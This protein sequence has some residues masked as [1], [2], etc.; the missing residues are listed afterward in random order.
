MI[1]REQEIRKYRDRAL[2]F[3]AVV[4]I[5]FGTLLVRLYY[6]QIIAGD[7]LR[8]YSEANR[9]RKE[10]LLPAR[11]TI[12]DRNG[13][14]IVDNRASFDV[15]MLP[16]F[17]PF[18]EVVNRRLAQ[19]LQVPWEEMEKR[20]KRAKKKQSFHAELIKADVS[21]DV[22]AAIE[23]DPEGF[24]GVYIEASIQRRYPYQDVSAQVLGYVGE[25]DSGDIKNASK[26]GLELEPG[27]Y[28]GKMG[29]EKAY[30]E[31]LRGTNGAG[32]VEVDA[33][34]RRRRAE[35][36]EKLLGFEAQTEPVPGNNLQLTL[37]MDLEA[38]AAE[39]M[40]RR[41]YHGSVVALDPQSGEILVMVNSPSYDPS[42]ITGREVSG[43]V[44][45]SLADD[46]YR[47]LR[48]RAIQDHYPPGS[49][50][51]LFVAI[52]GLME[53]AVTTQSRVNCVGHV[54]M[55]S[56]RFHCWKRHG[57]VD[58]FRSIKESCDTF[59][60]KAGLDLGVDLMA[61]YARAFG[62]GSVTGIN[63]PSETSGLI[64][65]SEW[66]LKRFND[67]WHPGENLSVAIGQGYVVTTPLQLATAYAA[68]GNK[69]FLYK[70]YIVKR[71]EGRAGEVIRDYRPELRRKIDVTSEAFEAVKDGLFQVMNEPGGTA[72]WHRSQVVG[73][74]GKTGTSQVRRFKEM[75]SVKCEA[76][77]YDERHHGWYVGYAPRVN[78]RIVVAV[79]GE[80]ICHGSS[81]APV[82]REVVDAYFQKYPLPEAERL[83]SLPPPPKP[84]KQEPAVPA[85]LTQ[86]SGGGGEDN[87]G[88][89]TGEENDE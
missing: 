34:G 32:F 4:L 49:T 42:L 8:R 21:K 51:K 67:K 78:P 3:N 69:G 74:S 44:W 79:V 30:D 80:H 48:N 6:L 65:D 71:I 47:P 20:L 23:M 70:P 84:K 53:K 56:R 66:K 18:T 73:I 37:D 7:E 38:A 89:A 54:Q 1:G 36:G 63:L 52:A 11:G 88:L 22:I 28:I 31:F 62:L 15:V 58:F 12:Y 14:V 40:K 59:Y 13:K 68:I 27:D 10:K 50:F 25:V 87:R 85:P 82:V 33:Q 76:L 64:P 17:Y 2:L 55:G 16:Q 26:Q 41:Q 72:Y 9:L 29:L 39:A 75:K 83:A 46:K 45:A 43:S 81:A 77:P 61:K 19:A 24:P 35:A 60:Y 5:F 57:P 86:P